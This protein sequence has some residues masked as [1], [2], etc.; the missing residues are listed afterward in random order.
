MMIELELDDRIMV[1]LKAVYNG[2]AEELNKYLTQ[3]LVDGIN[4][5][6]DIP[7]EEFVP[8]MFKEHHLAEVEGLPFAKS[9]VERCYGPKNEEKRE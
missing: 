4:A 8:V 6:M 2:N 7:E 5:D 3:V 9:L 1:F